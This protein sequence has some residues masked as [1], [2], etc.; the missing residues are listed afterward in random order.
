MREFWDE[1][2]ASKDYFYGTTPNH[3]LSSITGILKKSARILCIGEGEGRNAVYL[4][5]KGYNVTAVDFSENGK[6]KAL[7]LAS[8]FDVKID[9]QI[10]NLESFDFEN[11][12]WDA[13]I[14]IFCHLPSSIRSDVHYRLE[15]GLKNDGFFI[16]QAYNPKQLEFKSG[17]PK[18]PEMLYTDQ[19]I[20]NDFKSLQWIRLENSIEYLS[21][22]LGHN[23]LSSVLTGVGVKSHI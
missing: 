18:D 4:Q 16:F 22:G 9:Y 17:G 14:S 7:D 23:G 6:L 21:E 8:Q 13:V 20:K 2:Y 19:L 10:S 5:A 12:K 1:R 15:S 11:K 3:F